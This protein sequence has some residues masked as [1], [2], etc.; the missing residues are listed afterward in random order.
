MCL[1][2]PRT[3]HPQATMETTQTRPTN[4][5]LLIEVGLI[6]AL[7]VLSILLY[8]RPAADGVLRPNW[9]NWPTLAVLFFAIV[10][11]HTWRRKRGL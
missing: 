1:V 7:L 5:Y 10:G 2:P 4:R 11:L 3:L 6:L 9:W 8:M